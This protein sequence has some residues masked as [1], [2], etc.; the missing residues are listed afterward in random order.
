MARVD[1][2][3]Q[4][5]EPFAQVAADVPEPPERS[6]EAQLEPGVRAAPEP[7]ECSAQVV[8]ARLEQLEPAALV[9]ADELRLGRLGKLEEV[10]GMQ[11]V[12]LT[13]GRGQALR[14]FADD[15]EQP[16]VAAEGLD[17]ARLDQPVELGERLRPGLR[18]A[19]PPRP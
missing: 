9:G 6:R 15:L 17:D 12:P 19:R 13:V 3:L 7:V 2:P 5:L 18:P 1:R 8:V 10:R 16:V 4:A 14:V 11:V